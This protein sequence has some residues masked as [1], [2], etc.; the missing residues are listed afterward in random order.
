MIP[1]H[2]V[3]P[4]GWHKEYNGYMTAGSHGQEGSSMFYCIDENLEQV[5]G[6]RSND[7]GYYLYTVYATGSYVPRD[8][9]YAL[10]CVVCTK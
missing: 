1:S 6:T 2:Y 5:K 7:N 10:S 3:C 4:N 9:N 8:G